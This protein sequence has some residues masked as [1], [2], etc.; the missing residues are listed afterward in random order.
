MKP[1]TLNKIVVV[2]SY[3]VA[4]VMETKRIPLKGETVRASNFR[5]VHGGKG[6][7]QAVQAARLGAGVSFVGTVGSDN[8]GSEFLKLCKQENINTE[9]VYRHPDLPTGA[10]FIICSEDGHNI[11][12]IDIGA[13]NSFKEAEID[14]ASGIFTDECIVLLQLEIPINTALHAAKIAKQ[15]GAT[16]ILNPAPASNLSSED[17]S[18]IDY[19]TPNE[20]EARVC[21]GIDPND[22]RTNAE[23]GKHILN[24]GCK[25]VIITQGESGSLLVNRELQLLVE[26]FNI[27]NIVDSTGAGD[28]YNA[29]LAT[30]LINGLCIEKAMRYANAAGSLACTKRDTIPSMHYKNEIETFLNN[31]KI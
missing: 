4:L 27:K 28:A 5:T 22:T 19:L 1:K 23:I 20:K 9:F 10:G 17:L 31:Q 6:S 30:A 29:A 13:I 11:I 16:V 18:C 21:M 3:L 7:N 14:K 8:F 26:A 2:G 12:S 15:K 25:N 24:T